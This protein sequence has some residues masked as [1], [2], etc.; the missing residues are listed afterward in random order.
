LELKQAEEKWWER[1]IEE[2]KIVLKF[3]TVW[4]VVLNIEIQ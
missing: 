2:Y 4:K 1:L 3:A